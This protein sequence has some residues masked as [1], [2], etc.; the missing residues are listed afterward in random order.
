MQHAKNARFINLLKDVAISANESTSVDAALSE[1]IGGI[2]HATGWSVAHVFECKQGLKSADIWHVEEASKKELIKKF[3][4][5]TG[6]FYSPAGLGLPSC[7]VR[8]KKPVWMES[9][10]E[11]KNFPRRSLA[12]KAGLVSGMAFPVISGKDVVAVVELF[13]STHQPINKQFFEVMAQVGV[14]LGR[15]FER[16]AAQQRLEESERRSR[17]IIE[18][19]SDAFIAIDDQGAI[20]N[21]NKAA[22]DLFGWSR[23]EAIGRRISD[24]IIP[25]EY[26]EAH[27]KGMRRFLRTEKSKVIGERLEFPAL[28]KDGSR[29]SIEITLWSLKE[30]SGW[31]FFS[32][33]HDITAKKAAE[34]ELKRLSLHDALT[35]LPNRALLL[36]RLQHSVTRREEG[37]AKTAVFFIDLDNFKRINDSLGHNRGDQLLMAVAK[38]LRQS[39]RPS[40]TVA[41]LSGDEFVVVCENV[42]NYVDA[43]HIAQRIQESLRPPV[44][45]NK[46]SLFVVASIGIAIVGPGCDPEEALRLADIAMY[47]AKLEGGLKYRIFDD[48][49]QDQV[50]KKIEL[51]RDLYHALEKNELELYY[52]PIVSAL[53]GELE[54]CEALL[55]WNHPER[56]LIL[57]GDFV[58]IAEYS[59][60]INSIG[61]WIVQEV[62]YQISDWIEQGLIDFPKLVS[63]NLSAR[64]LLQDDFLDHVRRIFDKFKI[65]EKDVSLCFE[66]T[67]S[68]VMNDLE[69]ASVML[70]AL[71]NLG[72]KIA[73]DDFGTGFASLSYMRELPIDIIKIDRSFISALPENKEDQAI[74]M[75]I[76]SLAH[77]LGIHIVAEGVE[78]EGQLKFLKECN[79]SCFQ[80][81]LFSKPLPPAELKVLLRKGWYCSIG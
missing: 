61:D 50:L 60:L 69:K 72:C 22:E 62:C 9:I 29:L 57:P 73:L 32:F 28:H 26:R 11:S 13:S 53:N 38:R 80:G 52:Q 43:T 68:V 10:K 20:T 51:E 78:T 49:M 55:R 56:G 47:K 27:S 48:V 54:G 31:S 37:G 76:A 34:N 5:Y 16:A 2:C 17:V 7:A 67:E 79:I 18:S 74:V 35:G 39:M 45:L 19:A 64:Q 46:E 71:R 25:E 63:V 24:T 36:D 42:N 66:V 77:T 75:S 4:R 30:P 1:V 65:V 21:W 40:D 12:L 14:Q 6:S 15:V 70:Q 33:S 58:P 23:E 59:G 44:E 81:F 8:R 41:R 3:I